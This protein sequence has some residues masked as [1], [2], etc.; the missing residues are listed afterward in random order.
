MFCFYF[1]FVSNKTALRDALNRL[2]SEGGPQRQVHPGPPF[3]S[4]ES[5]SLKGDSLNL[6]PSSSTY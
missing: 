2:V 6:Y 3:I 1:S 4:T 5:R